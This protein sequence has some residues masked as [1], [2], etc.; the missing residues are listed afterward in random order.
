MTRQADAIIIGAGVIGAATAYEL[1][2][3]GYKTL[4]IDKLPTSGYGPTSNSCAIVRAH[5]SSRDGVAMAYEGFFYWQDWEHYLGVVDDLG[6]RA[7]HELRHACCSRARPATTRRSSRTTATSA[8]STRSGTTRRAR[9]A[10]PGLRHGRVLAA[11]APGRPAL[12]GR[13]RGAS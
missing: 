13:V 12:L 4:N 3:R 1:R 2:K 6:T 10:H 8:S 5:Y 9:G 11:Q 7:V